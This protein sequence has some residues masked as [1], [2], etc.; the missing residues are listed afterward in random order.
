VPLV[1]CQDV[2]KVYGEGAARLTVLDRITLRVPDGALV[3]LTGPSGSGKT[4]LL[5][6][7]AG[8]DLSTSG[9]VVVAGTDVG[10]LSES[11]RAGWRYRNVG[12]LFQIDTLLPVLD[13][14]ENV[15]LPLL[16]DTLSRRER[17]ERALNALELVGLGDRARHATHQ[18]SS[19]ER[20]RLSFARAIV[21]DPKLLVADEP[22]AHLD[23]GGAERI[24]TL[25]QRLNTD[26]GK[27][28]V[29]VTRDAALTESADRAYRLEAGGLRRILPAPPSRLV[30][31]RLQ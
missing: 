3:A 5:N 25:L 8:L 17:R 1:D 18:L 9:R 13:A 28:I 4:T 16:L 10:G 21:A 23:A 27:T 6:L 7:I 22:T 11:E 12:C 31:A 24:K 19:D 20:Q 15:E 30:G 2:I 29:V 26:L 14:I